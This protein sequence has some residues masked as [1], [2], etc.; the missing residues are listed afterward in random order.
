MS[1]CLMQSIIYAGQVMR[2]ENTL[3]DYKVPPVSLCLLPGNCSWLPGL[4]LVAQ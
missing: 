3:A 4:N 2:D 1:A